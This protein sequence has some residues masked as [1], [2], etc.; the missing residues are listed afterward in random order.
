VAVELGLEAGEVL[1]GQ[2]A[3]PGDPLA[4]L[5]QRLAELREDQKRL[6][7]ERDARMRGPLLATIALRPMHLGALNGPTVKA[8]TAAAIA[9]DTAAAR[10]SPDL[11]A[12]E[13]AA[14]R[15]IEVAQQA[16]TAGA[17][18][19]EADHQEVVQLADLLHEIVAERLERWPGPLRTKA[20]TLRATVPTLPLPALG[21]SPEQFWATRKAEALATLPS[22]IGAQ[23]SAMMS[24]HLG[25][26]LGRLTALAAGDDPAT[27]EQAWTVLRIL[28]A[29]KATASRLPVSRADAKARLH[30]VLDAVAL[31]VQRLLP[32]RS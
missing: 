5:R 27:E 31:S 20:A 28:R 24:L 11:V 23:V 4:G 14:D 25:A 17:A 1:L 8:L 19:R 6:R 29:Y 7:S 2:L 10:S 21:E 12:L 18:L 32:A 26:E 15:L 9:F 22:K 3:P 16:R 30:A 13:A